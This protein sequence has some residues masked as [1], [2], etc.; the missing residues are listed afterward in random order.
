MMPS[1]QF[2]IDEK[3]DA[4][5]R[6]ISEVR[7]ELVRAVLHEKKERNLSQH[8]VAEAVGTSPSV[9]SRQL[10]GEANLTLRS[11]AEIAWAIGWVPSFALR[12]PEVDA[13]GNFFKPELT[14][15]PV[16]ISRSTASPRSPQAP[17]A[18]TLRSVV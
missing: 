6:F 7:D 3:S 17:D 5:S 15:G 18:V 8:D 11:I 1:Y 10:S 14:L 13:G 2:E 16:E 4:A 9:I 12:K